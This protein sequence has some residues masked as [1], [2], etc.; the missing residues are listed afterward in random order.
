MFFVWHGEGVYSYCRFPV[1][2]VSSVSDGA[3][4]PEDLSPPA[5]GW[6]ELSIPAKV[7]F[8]HPCVPCAQFFATSLSH[9][10]MFEE[11]LLGWELRE[12]GRAGWRAGAAE[13][14]YRV[15]VGLLC[16]EEECRALAC[17]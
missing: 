1:L 13:S 12:L 8:G 11:R 6:F 7:F 17:F 4:P 3:S 16:W 2:Y 15:W 5:V 9:L 10:S 14:G